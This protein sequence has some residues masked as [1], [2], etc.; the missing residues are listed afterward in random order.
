[1]HQPIATPAAPTPVLRSWRATEYGEF[2]GGA[3]GRDRR[4][5]V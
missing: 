4:G 5:G 2:R 1:M 3:D